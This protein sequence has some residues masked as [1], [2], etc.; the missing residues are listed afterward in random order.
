MN[1][2]YIR[3]KGGVT[4]FITNEMD[5]FEIYAQVAKRFGL[6]SIIDVKRVA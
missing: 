3:Y 4:N 6:A 1:K 5:M 2:V